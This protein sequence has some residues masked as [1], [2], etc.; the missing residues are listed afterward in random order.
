M[1]GPGPLGDEIGSLDRIPVVALVAIALLLL[2]GC[3][4]YSSPNLNLAELRDEGRLGVTISTDEP[5]PKDLGRIRANAR[6]W[7][8]G[9]CDAATDQAITKL[10]ERARARGATRVSELQF[11]GRWKHRPEP[12]CRR[13]FGYAVFV[14]P[15]FLPFPTSVTVA[16]IAE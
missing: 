1:D 8:F 10:A 4:T 14:L 9:S 15:L 12:A 16:G 2:S 13:N 6:T 5:A 11:R 3:A 7:L